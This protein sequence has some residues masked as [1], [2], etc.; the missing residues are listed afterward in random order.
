MNFK[1]YNTTS[2]KVE[3]FKPIESPHVRMYSCGMTVNNYSHIG[4]L[5]TYIGSDIL[6]RALQFAGYK[7]RHVMNVTDVGHM[8]SDED[9]GEDK[10]SARAAIEGLSPWDIA[11]KYEQHFLTRSAM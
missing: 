3:K 9:E 11:R 2:R 10:V 5:K 7:V 6:R 1:L 8:T 4:H